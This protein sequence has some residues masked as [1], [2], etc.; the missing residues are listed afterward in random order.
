MYPKTKEMRMNSVHTN[1]SAGH[2]GVEVN[3][4]K[5]TDVWWPTMRQDVQNF[6]ATCLQC[7]TKK[8]N[9]RPPTGEVRHFHDSEPF[10]KIAADTFG[11]IK[12]TLSGNA[13]VIVIIDLFT[14]YIET[15]ATTDQ[16][17]YTF[18]HVLREYFCRYGAPKY[19]LTDNGAQ[20][21][22]KYVEGILRN[23][24]V[25][26]QYTT[27]EHSERNALVERAIQTVQDQL[28]LAIKTDND[29]L[30]WDAILP[31]VTFSINTSMNKSTKY[32]PYELVYRRKATLNSP[33]IKKSI[34]ATD[35]YSQ[36]VKNRVDKNIHNANNNVNFSQEKSESYIR[37]RTFQSSKSGDGVLMKTKIS[38]KG[39]LTP[40]YISPYEVLEKNDD[41]YY[42][43]P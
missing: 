40:N 27:P 34:T 16:K 22:N 14:R 10:Q 21:R 43:R 4:E 29:K 3:L 39:K 19:L 12:E 26:Y 15:K 23:F 5:L 11:P 18:V 28:N 33:Y 37:K 41:I 31:L 24:G 42:Q 35:L 38:R 1:L 6:T 17:A 25:E 30:N 13:F 8:I 9:R 7:Q 2:G 20:F 36:F 32:S